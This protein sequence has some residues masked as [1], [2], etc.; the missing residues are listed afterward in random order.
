MSVKDAASHSANNAIA[1]ADGSMGR[2]DGFANSD[3]AVRTG[4]A[5]AINPLRAHDRLSVMGIA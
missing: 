2:H 4:A 5:S 3:R 1:A